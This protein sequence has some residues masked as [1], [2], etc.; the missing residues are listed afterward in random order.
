MC[1]FVLSVCGFLIKQCAI[2]TQL[3]NYAFIDDSVGSAWT[4]TL[5]SRFTTNAN[6][7]KAITKIISQKLIHVF[8]LKRKLQ[9]IYNVVLYAYRMHTPSLIT[10]SEFVSHVV[11]NIRYTV[12]QINT[13][14]YQSATTEGHS[15][16]H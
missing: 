10:Q 8:Y 11:F 1:V 14:Q 16:I 2:I 15:L 6:K 3:H 9:R 7:L 12:E 4:H 5:L 13:M